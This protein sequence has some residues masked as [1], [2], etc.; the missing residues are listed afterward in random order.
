[1]KKGKELISNDLRIAKE[2]CT[3]KVR[4]KKVK[5]DKYIKN[6]KRQGDNTRPIVTKNSFSKH[7]KVTRPEEKK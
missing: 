1:M 3:D 5:L 7:W 4:Y 2:Q 6:R